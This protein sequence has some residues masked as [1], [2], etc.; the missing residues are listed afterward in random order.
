MVKIRLTRTGKKNEPSYRVVITP[1]REKRET[2]FIELIG[3]YSPKTKVFNVQEERVKYWLG[4]GA[5]PTE[6]VKY[7]LS[8]KGLFDYKPSRGSKAVASKKTV[9]RREKKAK[10]AVKAAEPKEEKTEEAKAE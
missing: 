9:E 5:Q 2:R 1:A 8:K 3:N 4:V 6:T 10:K 7:L